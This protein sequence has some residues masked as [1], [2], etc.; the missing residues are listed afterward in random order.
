VKDETSAIFGGCTEGENPIAER[1]SSI[2]RPGVGKA[3]REKGKEPYD[4]NSHK[5]PPKRTIKTGRHQQPFQYRRKSTDD[6]VKTKLLG[7]SIFAT[8]GRKR[9]PLRS[10]IF[11]QLSL[12][13]EARRA[14]GKKKLRTRTGHELASNSGSWGGLTLYFWAKATERKVKLFGHEGREKRS[15]SKLTS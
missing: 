13:R 3:R 1:V 5:R 7:T 4:P 10:Q 11:L 8:L 12:S 6:G 2:S 14:G 9:K 15:V